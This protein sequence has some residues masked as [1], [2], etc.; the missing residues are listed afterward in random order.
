M[1]LCQGINLKQFLFEAAKEDDERKVQIIRG[2]LEGLTYIHSKRI[3]HR[4]LKPAN[5]FLDSE[6]K[7]PKI[8][9]FG[10]ATTASVQ[11]VIEERSLSLPL[12]L[13]LTEKTVGL[14]TMFYRAPE[15]MKVGKYDEKVDLY[16]LGLSLIHI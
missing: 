11:N 4:D 1:E 16:S 13:D 14:G 10:L 12:E 15:Q 3:I 9:D 7:R 5:I 8:G 2:I 6:K